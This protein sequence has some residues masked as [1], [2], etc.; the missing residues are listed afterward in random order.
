MAADDL[1]IP[2]EPSKRYGSVYW[3]ASV[4]DWDKA[5]DALEH[6]QRHYRDIRPIINKN[7]KAKKDRP[8]YQFFDGRKEI[9]LAALKRAAQ[10]E[11]KAKTGPSE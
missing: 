9:V 5:K 8:F 1:T 11:E 10:A 6:Y 7:P 2:G 4:G 3:G